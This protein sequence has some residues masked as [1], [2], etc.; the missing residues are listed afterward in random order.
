MAEAKVQ[1]FDS[2]LQELA[3]LFKALG[4]PARLQI[5]KFLA[6][7]NSCFTG[8]ITDEVPLS[9]TTVNQH[10]RE[11]KKAGFI[12]GTVQGVKTNYCINSNLLKN[13]EEMEKNFFEGLNSTECI[14]C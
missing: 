5:L 11:L 4:H 3:Q 1:L 6:S 14:D 12:L 2:E 7:K 13:L 8:N 10:L 9:R